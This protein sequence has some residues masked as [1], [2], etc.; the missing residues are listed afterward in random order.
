[1]KF[2]PLSCNIM[3]L[4]NVYVLTYWKTDSDKYV[5]IE[6]YKIHQHRVILIKYE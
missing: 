6:H 5:S 1:V 3:I 4:T 2:I